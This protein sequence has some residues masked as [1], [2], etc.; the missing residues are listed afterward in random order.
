MPSPQKNKGKM[1]CH[2]WHSRRTK[3]DEHLPRVLTFP[4]PMAMVSSSATRGAHTDVR[5]KKTPKREVLSW[6]VEFFR[7]L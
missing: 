7:V 6:K 1:P 4:D 5:E 3:N 2:K